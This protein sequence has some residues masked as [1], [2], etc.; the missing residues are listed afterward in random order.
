MVHSDG[1][2]SDDDFDID[3]TTCTVWRITIDTFSQ[4]YRPIFTV[5]TGSTPAVADLPDKDELILRLTYDGM[6]EDFALSDA[7]YTDSSGNT[8]EQGFYW[9]A[10]HPSGH[11]TSGETMTVA[12]LRTATTVNA[13]PTAADNTVTTGEDRTYTFTAADFGFADADADTLASV[14]IETLPAAGTL[15]LD[16]TAVMADDVVT[17]AQIDDGDLTFTPVAGASGDAYASFTFKVNDGTVDSVVAYTMTIDVTAATNNAPVFSSSNVP[18][19]IA[20]NTA[21]GQ[22]VGAAVEA[23]DDDAGDTLG[24]TLGGTD[25]ASFDFVVSTGQIRTKSGVSYDFE[26]KSSYTVTVTASDGTATAVADVTISITDEDEP[27]DAPATPTVSAVSGSTTSLSV[28]WT[29]P[30]NAGKPP[31]ASYDVQY[32]VGS[33]GTWT[34]GPQDVTGTTTTITGL[35]ADTQYEVQVRATNAEGDSDWSAPPGSGRTNSPTNTAVAGAPTITGTAQVGQTLTAATTGITDTNGLTS[36]TYTYQWIRV[37][38]TEADITDANSSTYILVAADLGKTI[39]VRVTFDDDGGNTEMLTSEATATVVAAPTAA[40]TVT[41]VDVTSTPASDGTYGTGEMIQFT[42]TFDQAVT[43]TGTPEFEFCLVD[44]HG[45]LL[46]RHAPAGSAERRLRER[47]LG[48]DDARVQLHGGRRRCRR[49]RHLGRRPGQHAEARHGGHDPGHGERARRRADPPGG[50]RQ[51]RPQGQRRGDRTAGSHAADPGVG[52]RRDAHHRVDAPGQRRL[53]ARSQLRALPGGGHDRMEQLVPGQHAGD[54]R[55]HHES[56]GEYGLRSTGPCHKCGWIRPVG[57][58]GDIV[59]HAGE[60]P[61]DGGAVDYRHGRGRAG[62]DRDGGHHR[63]RRRSAVE[64]HLP[65]GAG[66]RRRHLEPG[67]HPRRERRDLHP[68]RR[69]LGQ[70]AQGGGELHRRPRNHGDAD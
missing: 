61:G 21:A 54:A 16:G 6:D 32:R 39:K 48:H 65:V 52:H 9:S 30:A 64:L 42:V 41:E 36:P 27:P 62:A 68:D 15:A 19:D 28:S 11:P 1:T 67:G 63:G 22:N 35:T 55:G 13:A 59:Q 44:V 3:G 66:G 23:T 45:V 49:Q 29:A 70:E 33:S 69:R 51:D 50:G 4:E 14:R 20:E 43:V 25:A 5:A 24:Y 40:P 38:G 31:I 58:W 37:N 57:V 34:D 2:L 12:L 10:E 26:A 17:K 7:T 18:R 56:S 60:H 53:A 46:A 47:L 8:G